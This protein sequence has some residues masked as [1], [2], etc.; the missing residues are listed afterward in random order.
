MAVVENRRSR[1][2]AVVDV[3]GPADRAT[4]VFSND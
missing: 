1:V 4:I 3:G 2:A